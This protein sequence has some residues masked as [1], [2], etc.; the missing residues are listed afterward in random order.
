MS[1]LEKILKEELEH[2]KQ[3]NKTPSPI[4]AK[5]SKLTFKRIPKISPQPVGFETYMKVRKMS[6]SEKEAQTI[7]QNLK[8]KLDLWENRNHERAILFLKLKFLSAPFVDLTTGVVP[9]KW[10][11][12]FYL[13]DYWRPLLMASLLISCSRVAYLAIAG[14]LAF[15]GMKLALNIIHAIKKIQLLS[16]F[17]LVIDLCHSI[18]VVSFTTVIC[19]VT[20]STGT[21]TTASLVGIFIALGIILVQTICSL[22][23]MVRSTIAQVVAFRRNKRMK[24]LIEDIRKRQADKKYETAELLPVVEEPKSPVTAKNKRFSNKIGQKKI[25]LQRIVTGKQ[26]GRASCRER[27]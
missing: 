22:L 7:L 9:G 10:K 8:S 11:R 3:G 4:M 25:G 24:S 13:L 21:Q 14:L 6:E 1:T 12:F 18:L 26:I 16:P 5:L 23:I 15:E 19:T 2:L 27:V 17:Y 20:N